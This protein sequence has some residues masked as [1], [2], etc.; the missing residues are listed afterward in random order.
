MR[1]S[2]LGNVTNGDRP[3]LL[4]AKDGVT[5]I[6]LTTAARRNAANKHTGGCFA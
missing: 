5:P 1:G 2:L 6:A 3:H 4:F